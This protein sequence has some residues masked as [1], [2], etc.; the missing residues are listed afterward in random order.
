MIFTEPRFILFFVVCFSVFW[1]LRSHGMKK[2]WLLVCSYFFYGCW[3]YRFLI[4]ILALTTLDYFV[5]SWLGKEQGR[6]RRKFILCASLAANLGV[7][8]FF[9]Y[10]NFFVASGTG[11][12]QWM[13]FEVGVAKM[14]IILPVGISFITFQTLSYTIDVYRR[15]LEPKR[16]FRDFA[17]FVA[18]FPQLVAGPIVRARD[19]LPQLDREPR[20]ADVE[21]RR[22]L[23]LFL[24]GFFKKA[25]LADNI[26]RVIDPVFADPSK[27]GAPD[28]TLSSIL[29]SVQIYCDFSG[30]SDMAIATAGLFGYQLTRN[31]DFPYFSRNIQE[32]WRRWHI[33]LSTWLR[34][35]L[36]ISLGGG[37]GGRLRTYRN[38]MLT[39]VLGGLWHGANMT[40][41]L[42]GFLHGLAL[43]VHRGFTAVLARGRPEP[44]PGAPPREP[45]ALGAFVGWVITFS[46]VVFLFT[47]FRLPSI[48]SAIVF[49]RQFGDIERPELNLDWWLL[50]AAVA[51]VHFALF[52]RGGEVLGRTRLVPD[53]PFYLS[54]GASCAA[55]L[56]FMPV[57]AAPFIYFQF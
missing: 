31:F 18:F 19:F 51:A 57:S 4:L 43:M 16:N 27:Y 28:V 35:Y 41:V 20:F 15:Q 50:L 45:S 46:W 2:N 32:F 40:F 14:H 34:D 33:S 26:A 48:D 29:Y 8:G 17:L 24:G 38:L 47:I 6:L 3:D 23:L 21:G 39:M 52:K 25:C 49:F 10:F 13:G 54:Y 53:V 22:W 37:R 55:V 1:L 7:L 56:Y 12:L 44:V 36:Y 30:Y 5:A 11:F 9:K 42:W